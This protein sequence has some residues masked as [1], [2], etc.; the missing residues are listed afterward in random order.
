MHFLIMMYKHMTQ[1]ET[2]KYIDVL[3]LLIDSYN[4]RPHSSLQGYSPNEADN[5]KNLLHVRGI[6]RRKFANIKRMSKREIQDSPQMGD[7]VRIKK[8]TGKIGTD[9][10][11]YQPQYHSAFY[12][13]T[14]VDTRQPRVRYQIRCLNDQ[15]D[16]IGSFYKHELSVVHGD[17]WKVEKI[18]KTRGRGVNKKHFVKWAHFDENWNSWINDKDIVT[19]YSNDQNDNIE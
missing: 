16:I 11:G 6:I 13:I 14:Q 4:K 10:R 9:T 1:N 15:V 18:L 17:I 5:P 12:V 19:T 2:Y 3:P 7:I 8:L